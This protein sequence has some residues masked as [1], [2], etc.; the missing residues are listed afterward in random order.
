MP[1]FLQDVRFA[2]RTLFKSPAF[3]AAV[4]VTIALGVGATTAMWTVVDRIVL[5]PLPFAN[6]NR[7]VMLCETST[8]T[9]NFCVASPPN[10]A[11]WAVA[12]PA[13]EAVGVARTEGFLAQLNGTPVSVRGAIATAGFFDAIGLKPALGRVLEPADLDRARNRVAVISDKLWR[14]RLNADPAVVGRT[15]SMDGR[16]TRVIG[17]LF[18]DAYVPN[19]DAIDAWKPITAGIDDPDKRAWRGFMTIGR[20]APN[21]TMASLN[22]QLEVVRGRL[23]AAFPDSNAGWGIRAVPVRDYIAGP[24]SRTLWLFLGAVGF[25]MLIACANVASLLLVR[26]T[27]RAPEFAVRAS[28]GAGRG[29]LLRQVL[30]ESLVLAA[31][32][33][34][35]G[36]LIAMYVTRAL[37]ELAPTNLPRLDEVSF[38]GRVAL[39]TLALTTLAAIIFGLAPARQ[40]SR[41]ALT[42]ALATP[43]YTGGGSARARSVLVV[44]E[45]ALALVLLVGAGLLARAFGKMASWEPGFD[46]AGVTMAFTVTPHATY[47]TGRDAVAALEEVRERVA[48]VPGVISVGLGSA[49]PLWGGEE[50][51]TVDIAGRPRASA[52]SAPA[53][54]WFDADSHYFGALGRRIVRGRGITDED[55]A[56]APNIAVV[57][58]A[59]AARFFPDED[60][61]GRRVTVQ[62]HS[63]DIV[64]IVA[65]VRPFQPEQP[66]VPEI[67]WPIRQYTRSAAYLVMRLSPGV[68][69]VEE[70]VHARAAQVNPGITVSKFAPLERVV[71]TRLVSPR[72]NMAL[73][74]VFALV[75]IALAAVGVYGVIS[76]TVAGR[77][78]ELGVRIALGA[79]PRQLVTSVVRQAMTLAAIGL[80]IGLVAALLLGR[81]LISLLH[82]V[83]VTDALTLAV[84]IGTFL[85]VTAFASV[86]PARRASRVDPLIALRSE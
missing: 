42:S 8:K 18:P 32:G 53:V 61:I 54:N 48:A 56:G 49:V 13:L 3:T 22:A 69:G 25:V 14:E 67:F 52:D 44:A 39:F 23:A 17:V 45:L 19:F 41:T 12:V 81:L 34:A 33:G 62:E 63:A 47:A 2:L 20:L 30:T 79:T 9:A 66:V 16:E 80:G 84:T 59:F 83:P 76:S 85:L 4:V 24:I 82:G 60:P 78:R 37:V 31:A 77:T 74:G 51:G 57:S 65:D 64:G 1:T 29:R 36:L 70:E 21:T 26:A 27:T 73:I 15:I 7:A 6:S 50:T 68:A 35:A 72:F 55:A 43:R 58:E 10:V 40:A 28:L 38:D 75:A 11:D 5:R 71:T 86:I 46:R